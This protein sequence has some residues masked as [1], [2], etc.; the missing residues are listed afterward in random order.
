MWHAGEASTWTAH[1]LSTWWWPDRWSPGEG[2]SSSLEGEGGTSVTPSGG[3]SGLSITWWRMKRLKKFINLRTKVRCALHCRSDA[4]CSQCRSFVSFCCRCFYLQRTVHVVRSAC[5]AASATYLWPRLGGY[6]ID[7]S[8]KDCLGSWK[9]AR[10]Q[11]ST[12]EVH[13]FVFSLCVSAHGGGERDFCS[14]S[15]S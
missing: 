6:I 15:W 13:R 9:G 3:W 10:V 2:G 7:Q 1:V 11:A 14:P 8:R 12:C 5:A 4:E